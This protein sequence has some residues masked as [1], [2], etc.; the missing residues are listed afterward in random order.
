MVRIPCRGVLFDLD[1]VLIDSTPAV[2]RVWK[3]WAIRHGLDPDEV[4]KRA[5]GR[6]SIST[7]R[8]L[9]PQA[10][11]E[12]ENRMVEQ[13]EIEDIEGIVPSAGSA[14]IVAGA[15]A[16]PL[17]DCYIMH[18]CAGGSAAA[19]GRVEDSGEDGDVQRCEERKAASGALSE[20][21]GGAGNGVRWI[22]SW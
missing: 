5:H 11:A 8:E 9:L 12:D 22:A 16:G 13:A 10:D 19:S 20:G 18:A 14:G 21:R 7:I 3:Q 4:V 17:D 15:A 2:A 1:G 6:P